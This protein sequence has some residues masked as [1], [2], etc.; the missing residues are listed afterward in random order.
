MQVVYRTYIQSLI[1]CIPTRGA[2][3]IE[4]MVAADVKVES[5]FDLQNEQ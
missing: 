5:L 4:E 2:N 1:T 3:Y